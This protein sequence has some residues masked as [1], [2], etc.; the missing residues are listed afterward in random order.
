M[1]ILFV[2]VGFAMIIYLEESGLLIE[3]FHKI[4]QVNLN[5]SL[6]MIVLI[7]MLFMVLGIMILVMLMMMMIGIFVLMVM[8]G[9]L[10]MVN[11]VQLEVHTNLVKF[12]KMDYFYL[13]VISLLL[14]VMDLSKLV[15]LLLN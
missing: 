3:L 15:V 14:I 6:L 12:L 11:L 2:V 1:E 8:F 7:E 4:D 9:L 13:E 10:V 5:V